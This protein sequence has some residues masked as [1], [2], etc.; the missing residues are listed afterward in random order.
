M[1]K[2]GRT[3]RFAEF[4]RETGQ[5][6]VSI[7]LDLDGGTKVD[8]NTGI[9]FLDHM[10]EVLGRSAYLDLGLTAK[11][12]TEIDDH[13]TVEEVGIAL[14]V[15]L[16]RA[17]LDSGTIARYGSSHVPL[18]DALVLVAI[19]IEGRG[20]LSYDVP[21]SRDEIGGLALENVREFFMA[22][23]LNAGMTIHVK[24]ISG[25]NDHHVCEAVFR[26]FGQALGQSVTRLQRD[27]THMRTT[28]RPKN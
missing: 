9:Q 17:L 11:G 7:S 18:D 3:V 19:D 5:A 1:S 25:V 16:K 4:D 26:A 13:H 2:H 28:E 6:Y 21:F 20:F 22:L 14:G 15:A 23:A 24:K 12:D 8:V 10:L 27:P